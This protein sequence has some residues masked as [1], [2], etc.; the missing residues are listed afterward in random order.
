MT[1]L[2]CKNIIVANCNLAESNREG[3]G[4]FANDD[5]DDDDNNDYIRKLMAW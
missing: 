2:L 1:T 3:Y 5:D 4:C